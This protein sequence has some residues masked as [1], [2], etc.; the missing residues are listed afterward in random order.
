[1]LQPATDPGTVLNRAGPA[2]GRKSFALERENQTTL[3]FW[4]V[5]S[6]KRYATKLPCTRTARFACSGRDMSLRCFWAGDATPRPD[7]PGPGLPSGAAVG[8][9]A[10]PSAPRRG[11][12]TARL[13]SQSLALALAFERGRLRELLLP[14]HWRAARPSSS[15]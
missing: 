15:G 4:D 10:R 3:N 8:V 6:Y 7:Q 9:V 12:C 1:M 2:V 5:G 13:S 11:G 14:Q